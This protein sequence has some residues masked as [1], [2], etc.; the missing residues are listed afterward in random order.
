[1]RSEETAG[2]PGATSVRMAALAGA[3]FFVLIII[4]AN[5]RSGAPSATD[6]GRG[7]GGA[8]GARRTRTPSKGNMSGSLGFRWGSGMGLSWLEIR[9]FL[10]ERKPSVSAGIGG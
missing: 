8:P 3:V 6:S 1:M 4:H 10:A 2:V 7:Q 9:A 5:L